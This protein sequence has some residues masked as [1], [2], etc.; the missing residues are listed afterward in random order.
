MKGA[1][2]TM[3]QLGIPHTYYSTADQ[4]KQRW[5][6][7]V[8]Q[9]QYE[10]V[11]EA[12]AGRVNAS[13]ACKTMAQL[14][15]DAGW[16]LQEGVAV[17]DIVTKGPAH[18]ELITSNGQVVRA[19]KLVLCAGAW[20]NQLLQLLGCE[21]DLEIHS[22]AWGHWEV[23]P[24]AAQQLPQ[25]FCFN[26]AAAGGAD[27]D[28]SPTAAG[29]PDGKASSAHDTAAAWDGGLYYAFPPESPDEHKIKVRMYWREGWASAAAFVLPCVTAGCFG[30]HENAVPCLGNGMHTDRCQVGLATCSVTRSICLACLA[31][32][33]APPDGQPP[34]CFLLQVGID[35]TPDAP[36]FKLR[37]MASFSYQA[38][39]HIAGLMED[40]M[41]N[42]WSGVG[43]RLD[44]QAS[45]YTMTR[46]QD[47]V[48]GELPGHPGVLLFTGGSGR[49]F[50]FA[51]L[52]GRWAAG[53]SR[54][55]TAVQVCA[56]WACMSKH[57]S[58]AMPEVQQRKE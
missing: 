50:K 33:P 9:P 28:A 12:T 58:V 22:V 43:G 29:S 40:F 47:F 10:G 34:G 21:M 31:P 26:K 15:V 2:D 35:F 13:L 19:K 8:P 4:L 44:L 39:P 45:P 17:E 49:A 56:V 1:A 20:T 38:H 36:G 18:I 41:A 54:G 51:P 57:T 30:A 6:H 25:W 23:T 32:L 11:H 48:L 52:I 37:H 53:R 5:P 42:N 24:E 7:M 27:S 16:Q 55:D 14:A 46:D 3:E